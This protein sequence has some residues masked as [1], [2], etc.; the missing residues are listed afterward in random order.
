MNVRLVRRWKNDVKI[1]L[2]TPVWDG[3]SDKD[4]TIDFT[5]V[6]ESFE[7]MT[8]LR[9]SIKNKTKIL[10]ETYKNLLKKEDK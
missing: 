8:E 6:G 7:N 9:N 1:K 10:E 2:D 3:V 4:V 5:K